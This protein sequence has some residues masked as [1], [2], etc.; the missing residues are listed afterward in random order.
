MDE[1]LERYG[2]NEREIDRKV[3]KFGSIYHV[4]S[5]YESR[6][7]TPDGEVV[8]RGI[9]SIELFFDGI[10]FWIITWVFDIK[11]LKTNLNEREC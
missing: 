10:R 3:Q 6:Y 8:D 2:F 5:T 9:N 4:W 7:T 1:Y 11:A